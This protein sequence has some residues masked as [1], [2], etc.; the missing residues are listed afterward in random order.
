MD[1]FFSTGINYLDQYNLGLH[2]K[3]SAVSSN[4]TE[5]ILY[6]L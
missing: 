1:V 4:L 5:F 3:S 6:Y 2:R